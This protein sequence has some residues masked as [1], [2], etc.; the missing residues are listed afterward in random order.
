VD[1]EIPMG[2]R[3]RLY[4][5]FETVPAL[6][7]YTALALVVIIPIVF[8]PRAGAIYVLCVVGIMF[9]RAIRGSIDLARGFARYKASARVDWAAR[10]V[11]IGLTLDG[12][13]VPP[14][15][16][17][18]FHVHEHRALLDAVKTNPQDYPHPSDLRHAVIIAAYNESYE[19]IAPTIRGLLY[20]TTP[21]DQL[22]IFFAY[23]ERGGPEMKATVERLKAEY[24]HRFGRF[25]LVEHPRDIPEELAGKGANITY[26]GYRVQEWAEAEGLDPSNVIVTSLDCDNKPYESYFDY[27]S[28]EYIACTDRK[29][30]SFQPISLYLSNIWDAPAV[31]R[32]VASANC[33]FNLT[34]T[35][36]PF[37]LR[38]F[39]SH[40]QP[41]DALID[42]GFWSKRTIVEDGH[43]YW[44]S[45]F[46]FDGDYAV[47]AIH[48][49]IYQDAV[50]AGGLKQSMIAQ[51]KQLSRWSYGA[52]DVAF[53]AN[54][55]AEKRA[56]F[57]RTFARFLS[58]L[59]G[60][61]TLASVS[62]IIAV[63]GWVPVI[64]M[65]QMGTGP[66]DSFVREMPF[67]VG[68]I[69]QVAMISLL[70][71]IVV[72]WNL[73]PPRPVRYGPFRSVMMLGQ[74][75]LY[76]ATLLGYNATTAIYS[77][78]RL[79]VGKYREKFDV[80]EK[81]VVSEPQRDAAFS[82]STLST[83]EIEDYRESTMHARDGRG[84][85]RASGR[86]AAARGAVRPAAGVDPAGVDGATAKVERRDAAQGKDTS[87]SS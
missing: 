12:K 57:W 60:H 31:T 70:I 63:G 74:W 38:N 67:L 75:F 40:S 72:F 64:M 44:R 20:S 80:T 33:F 45:Y 17:G 65:S 18:S 39:A 2:R 16:P 58:L 5:F 56:P 61:V 14:S 82:G 73:I 28:Y 66:G 4:R 25:E 6:F 3:R 37:A 53:V 34:T 54:R 81:S 46:H 50:L 48:V 30:R 86:S 47:K 32:V 22:C 8:S 77:Q 1:N 55:M 13:R 43:Q 83:R 10:L 41:L 9:V 21:G 36:R 23:E 42:M 49:P 11:D 51:F 78:G 24:G 27:V 68:V 59:E 19:V 29:R 87:A 76:P 35:V 62:L 79:L 15:P 84:T 26:A 85:G 52:S 71:S 7:S 69:Q